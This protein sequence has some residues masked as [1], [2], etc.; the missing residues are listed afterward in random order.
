MSLF[1]D[2]S[3]LT[4]LGNFVSYVANST[5]VGFGPILGILILIGLPIL[6]FMIMKVS[7]SFDRAYV[8]TGFF[9]CVLSIFLVYLGLITMKVLI[10]ADLFFVISIYL[11]MKERGGEET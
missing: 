7:F 8:A 11:V 3:N 1:G 10:V 4:S 5:D 9:G 2:S 6:S